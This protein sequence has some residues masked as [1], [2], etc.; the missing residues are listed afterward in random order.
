[1]LKSILAVGLVGLLSLGVGYSA[2]QRN[3]LHAHTVASVTVTTSDVIVAPSAVQH[4]SPEAV[5]V[6]TQDYDYAPPAQENLKQCERPYPKNPNVGKNDKNKQGCGCLRKCGP[7]NKPIENYEA[8]SP[9]CKSHRHP[10]FCK[11][12]D[13]CKT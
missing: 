6:L 7:E 12:P 11:C 1:M 3:N 13:P 8:G 2:M 4:D 9:Q 10:D 5:K